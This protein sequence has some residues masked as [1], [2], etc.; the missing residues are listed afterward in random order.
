M[1]VNKNQQFNPKFRRIFLLRQDEQS[2]TSYKFDFEDCSVG[3][4]PL[5]ALIR[6]M[7]KEEKKMIQLCVV[8]L[9]RFLIF[10]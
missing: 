10:K 6:L 4:F 2:S 5:D 7:K 9:N 1:E 8:R 3:S